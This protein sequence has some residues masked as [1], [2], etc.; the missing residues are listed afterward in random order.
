MIE[1]LLRVRD[2]VDFGVIPAVVAFI[3]VSGRS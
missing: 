1:I 2:L 3:L